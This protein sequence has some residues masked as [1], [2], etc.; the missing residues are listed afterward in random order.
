MIRGVP[1]IVWLFTAQLILGYFLP[2]GTKF[3]LTLRVII[4]VTLFSAAYIAEVVRGG[5]AALPKGQYEGGGQ[6]RP[7]LLAVD[8]ADHPAAG[9]EDL[10]P[11]D[12]QH[13]HRPVQGH[14]AGR[15]HRPAS[16]RS[17]CR[18][19]SGRRPTGTASTGSS[20]SS[21]GC[22]SSSSASRWAATRS[23][24]R[25]SSPASIAKEPAHDRR[26]RRPRA[27]DRPEPRCRSRT[28]SRS[29]SPR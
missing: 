27:R 7:V 21:S 25:R 22:S 20:S 18:T 3:D 5:L 14:D 23:S 26:R 4:M 8:A 2:P 28:R 12:R 11:R 13:L 9:A 24:W 1:L 10:D 15:V 19:R 16:I 17:A 6:P 29:R